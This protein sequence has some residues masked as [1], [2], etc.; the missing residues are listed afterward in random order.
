M[1]SRVF[2]PWPA[3]KVL[4]RWSQSESCTGTRSSWKRKCARASARQPF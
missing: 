4:G 3:V 1:H 2:R